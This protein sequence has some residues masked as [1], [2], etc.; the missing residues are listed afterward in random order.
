M[1]PCGQKSDSQDVTAIVT[2]MTD[3]EQFF[4]YDSM[5][6]VLSDPGISQAVLCIEENNTW[7]DRVLGSLTVDSRLEIVRMP[8]E[9]LGAVRNRA[10]DHVQTPWIAYCDGDDVW[11]KGKTLIQ[12]TFANTTKCDFVGCDHYLTD[13]HGRIK[14]IAFAKYIPMP[15][16]WMVRTQIMRLYP[17]NESMSTAVDSDGEWWRRTEDTIC[18]VR[19]P[20][21]FV[22]YRVRHDSLSSNTPSKRRKAI[23]VAFASIPVLGKSILFLTWCIWLFGRRKRYIRL[24]D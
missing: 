3:G 5:E 8:L 17:F 12:R 11:C 24:K 10:L 2:A 23:A 4:L 20:R 14:A 22:R 21:L 9:P 16:S 13:E 18:K 1:L 6:A 19:C 7:V 15:S